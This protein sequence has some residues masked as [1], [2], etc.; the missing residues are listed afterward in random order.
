[1]RFL[2]HKV[3]AGEDEIRFLTG[4][5]ILAIRRLMDYFVA[6]IQRQ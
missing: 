2:F 6:P 4:I 5:R 1:M 3:K